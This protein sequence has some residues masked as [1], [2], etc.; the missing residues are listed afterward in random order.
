MESFLGEIF[1]TTLLEYYRKWV[2][3][4]F[5]LFQSLNSIPIYNILPYKQLSDRFENMY[6][7]KLN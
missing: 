4:Q 1:I 5:L 2:F 3:L 6:M 7:N